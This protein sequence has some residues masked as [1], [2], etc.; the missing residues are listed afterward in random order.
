MNPKELFM[1]AIEGKK[2]R[3]DKNFNKII[4][5]TNSKMEEFANDGY[6]FY[7]C[8]EVNPVATHEGIALEEERDMYHRV[9]QHYKNEGFDVEMSLKPF[10]LKISWANQQEEKHW[11][12]LFNGEKVFLS[13]LGY[14]DIGEELKHFKEL[15]KG[16]RNVF[17]KN[18]ELMADGKLDYFSFSHVDY[19]DDIDKLVTF[20]IKIGYNV[21]TEVVTNGQYDDYIRV[22]VRKGW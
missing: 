14:I 1:K 20:L 7:V 21:K 4:K 15:P 17:S 6:F 19:T 9:L 16:I 5:L 3:Q 10:G 2:K 8:T 11:K 22:E 12:R 13:K 18:L